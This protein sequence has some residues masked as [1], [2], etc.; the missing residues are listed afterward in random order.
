MRD[1]LTAGPGSCG[2][3]D[4]TG[5]GL[6]GRD[7]EAERERPPAMVRVLSGDFFG[8][9]GRP[10]EV[11]V[12]VSRRGAACVTVV[13]LPGKSI[14]ESRERI[15]AGIGNSG[16][17]FPHQ[18]RVLINLAPAAEQKDGSGFDLAIAVGILVASSQ[19]RPGRGW[20]REDAVLA[21]AGFLG[22]LGL[23]GELR[24]ITGA[25]I[26]A[27]G[28]R[29]AGVA[30]VV[31]PSENAAE[32]S[33]LEAL[34]VH[35]AA[36]LREVLSLLRLPVDA[37]RP[38]ELDRRPRQPNSLIADG[39][40]ADVRG[41]ESTKRALFL[42]AAGGHN[43]ILSGPPG[44]GKTMLARRLPGI[45]P[46]LSREDALAVLR[47]RSV[48]GE[49]VDRSDELAPP[50]RSPHHTTSY[51]G[52]VGGGSTVRPGE[53]TR[54]HGGVLFLD[55]IPEFQRRALEALREPLEE[56]WIS[57]GRS[58]GCVR[59]PARLLLVAAMNPC[60]CGY[61]GHPRRACRCTPPRVQSYRERISGPLLDRV[62]LFVDVPPVAPREI[63]RPTSGSPNVSSR[64]FRRAVIAA[65]ERQRR[66]WG[67]DRTNATI[68]FRCLLERGGAAPSVLRDLERRAE[69]LELSARGFS[70]VLR[71][72]RTIADADRGAADGVEI[73]HLDEALYYRGWAAAT[74]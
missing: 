54:A 66:R 39:D 5:E 17:R 10:V 51:A 7:G 27:D 24:P 19:L 35:P 46:P 11:Q 8:L 29:R 69:R 61:L 12:D 57:I 34:E 38:P 52:L 28:L 55:E 41:Q 45:L 43:T 30:R 15:R 72:A 2:R 70:R 44:V 25:L 48:V 33:H 58:T 23:Q 4:A 31:V 21:G 18:S 3:G 71:V 36:E 73:R 50:F 62:D 22:E 64:E 20:L 14:R 67:S 68:S 32:V 53:V 1:E 65:R 9:E 16:Y 63:L 49:A 59:L 40:F 60:P 74:N 47:V 26:A 42:A 56:G 13:G 6:P 37:L